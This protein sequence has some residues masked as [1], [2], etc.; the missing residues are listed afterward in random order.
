MTTTESDLATQLGELDWGTEDTSSPAPAIA[1]ET[2]AS[3]TTGAQSDDA[4]LDSLDVSVPGVVPKV[5]KVRVVAPRPP[6]APRPARRVPDENRQRAARDSAP[7]ILVAAGESPAT[8]ALFE[9]MWKS[10]GLKLARS[11]GRAKV[12]KADAAIGWY[13][14]LLAMRQ[15]PEGQR[16]PRR[17]PRKGGA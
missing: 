14:M 2:Y 11:I 8:I 5:R 13:T 4:S 9:Q 17:S 10:E 3:A 12:S 15:R 7:A 1:E 16:S 6:R